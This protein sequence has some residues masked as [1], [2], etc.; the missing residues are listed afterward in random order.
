VAAEVVETIKDR[1]L[2]SS[3][4]TS[5]SGYV[6]RAIDPANIEVAIPDE[7]RE[8]PVPF[9]ADVLNTPILET[10]T[11]ARIVVNRQTGAISVGGDIEISPGIVYLKN[12]V[13]EAAEASGSR[14]VDIDP[15]NTASPK[16]KSLVEA[17]NALQV[18][19][20]DVIEIL[21]VMERGGQ[22]GGRLI[23]Q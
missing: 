19:A 22:L 16:L 2:L 8:D 10:R 9:I 23:I 6:A 18:P 17:L 3:S 4:T 20:S 12:Y 15:A 21:K 1:R 11:D 13:V 5:H 7:Y 14:F